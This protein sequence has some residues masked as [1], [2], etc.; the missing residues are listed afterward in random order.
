MTSRQW[1]AHHEVWAVITPKYGISLYLSK[2]DAK[3][4]AEAW[5]IVTV[6]SVMQ[7]MTDDWKPM[8]L[9]GT[10]EC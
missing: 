6:M 3:R 1:K 5:D 4:V 9:A 10:Y 2:R 7:E 8:F